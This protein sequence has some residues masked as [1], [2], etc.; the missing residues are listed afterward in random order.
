MESLTLEHDRDGDSTVLRLRGE[1]DRLTV[2]DVDRTIRELASSTTSRLILDLRDLEFIDSAGLRSLSR[3]HNLLADAGR[4]LVVRAP[5]PA[6]LRLIELVG[7]L[8]LDARR[9]IYLVKV[10]RQ[11]LVVGASEAGFT[12]LGELP[13]MELPP[14]TPTESAS[15]ADLLGRVMGRSPL[16]KANPGPEAGERGSIPSAG[17]EDG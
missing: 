13:A 16:L 8:P 4:T 3:A 10:A 1:L 9:S 5:S 7:L 11:V 12:K 15:F 6:V 17:R 14:A 2:E